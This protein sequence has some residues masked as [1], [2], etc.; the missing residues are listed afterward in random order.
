MEKN[1]RRKGVMS[2]ET[3]DIGLH[4]TAAINTV[5]TSQSG[6]WNI[7]ISQTN[8]GDPTYHLPV[9]VFFFFLPQNRTRNRLLHLW[10]I[11]FNC[12][13]IRIHKQQCT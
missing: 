10:I 5:I 2:E 13:S 1:K 9:A 4:I 6:L 3:W 11:H 7:L 8:S 12:A